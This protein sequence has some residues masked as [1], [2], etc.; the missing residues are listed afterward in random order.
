MNLFLG[1]PKN[2]VYGYKKLGIWQTDEAEEAAL[3]GRKP[4]EI[5]IQ[6]VP[7]IDENGRS[8]EGVHAY[9]ADDRQILGAESPDWTFWVLNNFHGKTGI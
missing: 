7:K 5:K 9:S 1:E 4:G 8:D 2:T 3:Y 6:T